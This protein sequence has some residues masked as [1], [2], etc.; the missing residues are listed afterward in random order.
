MFMLELFVNLAV[1]IGGTLALVRG[2]KL[3]GRFV[4]WIFDKIE[5]MLH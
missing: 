1:L 5:D 2:F 4:N 3:I